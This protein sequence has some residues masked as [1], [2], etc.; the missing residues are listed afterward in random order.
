MA[1]PGSVISRRWYRMGGVLAGVALA[2]ALL[3]WI[4]AEPPASPGAIPTTRVPAANATAPSAA[5][6]SPRPVAARPVIAISTASTTDATLAALRERLRHSS[7]RGSEADGEIALGADG[8]LRLDAEL[9]RRFDYYLSLSGEFSLAEIRRLLEA[10]LRDGHGHA[11][12]DAALAAFDRY[13]G[14][15]DALASAHLPDDPGQRLA[16]LQRLQEAWFGT[17]AAALFGEENAALADTIARRAMQNDPELGDAERAEQ[18]AELDA[19]RSPFERESRQEADAARL[20]EEQTRQFEQLDMDDAARHAERAALWGEEAAERLA[21]LDQQR[22]DWD[23]RLGDYAAARQRILDNT[24]L[25]G[26][27]RQRALIRLRE[28]G[29]D[30]SEQLRVEALERAGALPGG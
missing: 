18:L 20:V 8:Q 29:F 25:D 30:A 5:S 28:S 3:W 21:A 19:R 23:Q 17:D 1:V 15:R 2:A 14:L 11:V 7:L 4:S 16:L 24:A 10:D 9:L 6:S 26:A 27:A 12:A 22:A 13:L